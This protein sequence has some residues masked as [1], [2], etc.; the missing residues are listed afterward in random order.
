MDLVLL[1]KTII[2]KLVKHQDAVS[3]KE[4]PTVDDNEIKIEIVVDKEDLSMFLE[5]D[6]RLLRAVKTI[7]IA[8]SCIN[9]KKQVNITI[10]SY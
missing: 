4:Y 10:E 8:S 5:N 9:L 2:E 3:V 7:V 6:G 1:T